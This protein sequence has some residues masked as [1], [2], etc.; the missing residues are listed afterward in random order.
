MK[1][2][3]KEKLEEIVKECSS[4]SGVL[5]KLN[6]SKSGSSFTV[7]KNK[8]SKFNI[9]VSHFYLYDKFKHSCSKIHWSDI[10]TKNRKD[11]REDGKR[12]RLALIESGVEY[13]CNK[14]GLKKWLEQEII[15]EVNHI[16]G[17]WKN[18]DKA[19][20]EFLCPNCHSLTPNF[21]RK[22]EK[23]FNFCKCGKQ[24]TNNYKA[25]RKCSNVDSSFKR[26]KVDRPVK[27]ELEKL[28]LSFP[29][30]KLA[31]TYNVT[32]NT[33]RKWCKFYKIE[34]PKYPK[35]YWQKKQALDKGK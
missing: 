11:Y 10:L 16:D 35:G 31:K 23:P 28:V 33:V 34:I 19:N 13:K 15:L 6:L 26:R 21:F 17:D 2:I 32:D 14:C 25:C 29:F 30:T 20:L 18:N 3:P 22:R 1:Y 24:I 5:R 8:I 27:E 12:L 7:I 9:D 4:Y